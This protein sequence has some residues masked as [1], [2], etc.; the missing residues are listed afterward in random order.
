MS[1]FL[2]ILDI[3]VFLMCTTSSDSISCV[4]ER[5][6]EIPRHEERGGEDE[7]HKEKKESKE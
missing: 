6:R 7:G 1:K 5:L 2:P 4:E 3:F